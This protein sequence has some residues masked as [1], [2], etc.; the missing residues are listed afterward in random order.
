MFVMKIYEAQDGI[1]KNTEDAIRY[2]IENNFEKEVSVYDVN[3][4]K[5]YKKTNE[6]YSVI[7]EYNKGKPLDDQI[8]PTNP[9]VYRGIVGCLGVKVYNI[10]LGTY[11][12]NHELLAPFTGFNDSV[13][14][15]SSEKANV[16]PG[17]EAMASLAMIRGM[18]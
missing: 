6:I 4:D 15:T 13:L 10:D 12:D 11:K 8:L 2:M 7:K 14:D 5:A 1:F 17:L 3:S 16:K 18:L 9:F